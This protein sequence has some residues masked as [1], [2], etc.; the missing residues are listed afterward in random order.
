MKKSMRL[1]I[2]IVLISLLGG[3]LKPSNPSLVAASPLQ[4][5]SV[6]ATPGHVLVDPQIY[7]QLER[8][9]TAR[10]LVILQQQAD[11]SGAG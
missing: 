5:A 4:P 8:Q 7:S 6:V 2:F 3:A 1:I 11:L 9:G 10:V